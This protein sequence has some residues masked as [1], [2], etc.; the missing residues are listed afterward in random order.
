M[1][2]EG[3]DFLGEPFDLLLTSSGGSVTGPTMG[4]VVEDMGNLRSRLL[5]RLR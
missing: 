4:K 1:A 3:S 5:T 2:R